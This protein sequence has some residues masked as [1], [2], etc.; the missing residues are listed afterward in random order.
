MTLLPYINIGYYV[1]TIRETLRS[2]IRD[3]GIGMTKEEL[4][5]SIFLDIICVLGI[6]PGE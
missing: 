1:S 2:S 5:L 4:L 3:T 6:D